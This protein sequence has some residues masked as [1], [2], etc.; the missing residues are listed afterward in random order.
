M[1]L[2][3]L[4]RRA[5]TWRSSDVACL[6]PLAIPRNFGPARWRAAPARVRVTCSGR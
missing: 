2:T 1:S 6:G 4:M 5:P 3:P